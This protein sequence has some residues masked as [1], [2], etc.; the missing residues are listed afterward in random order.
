[1][2]EYTSKYKVYP[3]PYLFDKIY[4][5]SPEFTWD[6]KNFVPPSTCSSNKSDVKNSRARLRIKTRTCASPNL[7]RLTRYGR[8]AHLTCP[9]TFT[10]TRTVS[11]TR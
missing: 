11:G 4:T 10:T 1:M 9:W 3:T 6:L 2:T 5:I 7:L 8:W